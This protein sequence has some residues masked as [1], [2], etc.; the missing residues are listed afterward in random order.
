MP[1]HLL[2][3][4]CKYVSL[5]QFTDNCYCSSSPHRPR[6]L[7]FLYYKPWRLR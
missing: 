3:E 7:L 5:H 4:K 2:S 6:T 1:Y